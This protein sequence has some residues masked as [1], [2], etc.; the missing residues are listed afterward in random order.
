[1]TASQSSGGVTWTPIGTMTLSRPTLFV[2]LAVASA[3]ATQSATGRFDNVVVETPAANQVP[4]VSLTAPANGA[5]YSAPATITL[6]ATASDADGSVTVV[7]FY[8][9][10][11]TLIGS[12]PTSPYSVTWSDVPAGSYQ[13]TAVARDDD[14]GVTV[15]AARTVTVNDP[16]LPGRAVFTASSNH[17]TAVDY[18]VVEIF[19]D[20]A[21]PDGAN[22]V[23]AQNIGKPPVVNGECESDIQAMIQSLAPGNYFGTVTAVGSAGSARSSPSPSFTR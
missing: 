5:T 21:D 16:Q 1:V 23:A 17:D 8:R 2:G 7:E 4:A 3:D 6:S 19:P 11:T 20:G 18:Y 22:A 14:A 15:S 13:L 10:G 12:D 9:G